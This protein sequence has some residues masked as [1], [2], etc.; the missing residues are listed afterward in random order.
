M[1]DETGP[2]ELCSFGR[3]G[4]AGTLDTAG[5]ENEARE[6]PRGATDDV[7]CAGAL[8]ARSQGFAGAA[9]AIDYAA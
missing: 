7:V 3:G 4:T 5:C 9:V 2:A 1:T 6:L 8:R